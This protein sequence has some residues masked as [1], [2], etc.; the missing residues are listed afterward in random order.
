MT[1]KVFRRIIRQKIREFLHDEFPDFFDPQGDTI[2]KGEPY[3]PT[4][5]GVNILDDSIE[6]RS[7]RTES[8]PSRPCKE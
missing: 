5:Y 4:M 1:E 7:H 6:R 8:E 3:P 2:L